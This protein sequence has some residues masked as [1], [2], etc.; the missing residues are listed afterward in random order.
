MDS[1]SR[2]YK[3]LQSRGQAELF[4]SRV[5]DYVDSNH[6]I[7]ALD[8]YVENLDLAKLGFNNTAPNTA[9]SGQP[10]YP[11]A[12]LLKLYLYGYLNRIKSSRQL[13]KECHRNVE[14]MWL[15][16]GLRPC[17]KT[18]SDFRSKN[19][20]AIRSTH[21]EFIVFCN[22][23]SLFEGAC[24]AVDGSFF[25]GSASRK[26]FVSTKGL[27]QAIKTVDDHIKD[28]ERQIQEQDT[29]ESRLPGDR[30]DPLLQEKLDHLKALQAQK[31][32]KEQTLEDLKSKGKTQESRTDPDA[33]LLNKNGQK[34]AGYN[35]QIATDSKHKLIVADEVTTDPNDSQQLAPMA[36]AAK[37]V[38]GSDRLEVL[39]DGGYYSAAQLL[40]TERAGVTPYV[41]PPQR[42]DKPG[43]YGRR[44]FTYDPQTDTYRCPAGKAL[45]RSGKPRWQNEQHLQRYAA[46]EGDCRAC[47]LRDQCVG[48][49]SSCREIW[50][51]EHEQFLEAHRQRMA[52]NEA[53]IKQRKALVEHPFGTIKERAGWSHFLLRGKD[54]VA[55]EWSLMAWAYNF[56]RVLKILGTTGFLEAVKTLAT[57]PS[58]A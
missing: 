58:T 29:R 12:A 26:S 32:K 17:Y 21:R 24:I 22:Q 28:W 48:Q 53:K 40:A 56:T 19:K 43:R 20:H 8:L 35:V 13:E 45:K 39:A 50:R 52:A 15:M 4:P 31:A 1:V 47:P 9:A 55:A 25:K 11:P 57:G 18:I 38:L 7:R 2:R 37:D 10:A 33:R 34:V 42:A 54:K 44:Q 49:K 46:S 51:S 41:P 16:Q 6:P 27:K 3:Q 36:T 14:A 5:D 30:L 23:L